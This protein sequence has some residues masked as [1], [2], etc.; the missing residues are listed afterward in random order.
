MAGLLYKDFIGIKGKRVLW[1]LLG[2]TG[3]FMLLR[4]SFPGD[5]NMLMAW[6]RMESETGELTEMTAGQFYDSLLVLPAFLLIACGLMLP[7][8]WTE[9]ICRHDEKNKTRQFA[10]ML[11]LEKN[12]YIAS[13][14]IFIGI[15]V[16]IL[17]SLEIVWIIIF[18]SKAGNEAVIALIESFLTLLTTF[19]GASLLIASIELPFFITLGVKKGILIKAGVMEGIVFLIVIYLYFGNLKV[20]ENFDIYVF[21]NWCKEHAVLVSAISIISPVVDIFIYWLSYRITCKINVNREVET[22]G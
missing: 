17:F 5:N 16:Y 2:L 21:V 3:L 11:P 14:Y 10:G 7:S 8:I 9:H 6:G 18:K 1:I 20:F 22:D 4:F 19:G 15:A 12:A 13:K